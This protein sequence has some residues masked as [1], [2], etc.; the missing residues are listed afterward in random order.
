MSKNHL[1][2]L[3]T[4]LLFLV[5]CMTIFG[6]G[7]AFVFTYILQIDYY[8]TVI[9]RSEMSAETAAARLAPSGI[10]TDSGQLLGSA[11]SI[12][13][14]LG[15]LDSDGDLDA[16]VANTGGQS[17]AI[18]INQ[19]GTQG[20]L[21][22]A[23]ADSGQTLGSS[24]STDVALGLLNGDAHLDAFIVNGTGVMQP[25]EVWFGSATGIFTNT[26]Q[27]LGNAWS[28]SVALG[29]LDGDN[30]LDA[31]VVNFDE[32]GNRVYLNQGGIQAGVTGIFSDSG[33]FLISANSPGDSV[34]V[35]LGDLNGDTVLDAVVGNFGPNT[36][37]FNDGTG[38]FT[39]TN[40]VLGNETTLGIALADLDGDIDLD[41]FTANSDGAG[42][43]VYLNQGG[44]QAGTLGV[45]ADSG[46]SLGTSNS[47]GIDLA[48]V[49]NDGDVD[50]VI[51]NLDDQPNRLWLNNGSGAFSDSGR[52]LGNRASPG[53]RLGDLDGDSDPDLFFANQ[54][55][56]NTVWFNQDLAASANFT[57]IESDNETLVEEIGTT[58]IVSVVLD[59]APA[60]NVIIDITSAYTDEVTVNPGSLAFT[61]SSWDQPQPFVVRGVEDFLIDGTQ[62]ITLTASVN[63]ASDDAYLSAADQQVA[64][65]VLDTSSG[66]QPPEITSSPDLDGTA[67]DYYGIELVATDPNLATDPD[68]TLTWQLTTFPNWLF[69]DDYGDGTAAL[70]GEPPRDSI[71]N[72]DVVIEVSDRAGATDTQSFTINVVSPA[73]TPPVA[74]TEQNTVEEDSFENLLNVLANDV[75]FEEDPLTIT[76]VGE[77]EHG[78]VTIAGDGKSVLYTPSAG[79]LGRDFF[80]YTISDGQAMATARSQ[81]FVQNV[82]NAP[83]AANDT[84]LIFEDT[85]GTLDVMANDSD[86][87]ALDEP[88]ILKVTQP[89]HGVVTI[90]SGSRSVT[91]TPFPNYAGP[92]N[93]TYTL[94][95]RLPLDPD[96][97]RV[98]RSGYGDHYCTQ[99]Q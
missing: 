80:E 77:A 74:Y 96:Q 2:Q 10:F 5:V 33:Q 20:G 84:F 28:E 90:E 65:T 47:E 99:Y 31:F 14:V 97:P 19:S 23:F 9:K 71:G 48:D 29:D 62:N 36:I 24:N 22:G 32:D 27:S 63:I 3:R 85:E 21:A 94:H 45:F 37:W 83:T 55:Q 38:T 6:L 54:N 60:S 44:I 40:Q 50:A 51:G 46:Q 42:N 30:D 12:N 73:N 41:I 4:R 93:F 53:V 95:D 26:A 86:P 68:E 66:N 39:A 76:S 17:N 25:N 75:D 89:E 64:V 61:P 16:F 92:D 82:N 13:L 87:D 8:F 81:V 91:Y 57:L 18:W 59:V 67:T 72:H 43:R 70:S 52:T 98:D 7:L 58:D 49:D 15:D 35:A 88:G 78:E 79:F 1:V 69:L 34:A 11:N 56:S